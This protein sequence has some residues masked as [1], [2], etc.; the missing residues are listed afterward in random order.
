MAK[1]ITAKLVLAFLLVSITGLGLAAGIANWLTVREFKQL[2]LD[3]ARERFIAD[4][5]RYYEANGHWDGVLEGIRARGFPLPPPQANPQATPAPNSQPNLERR[6]R[7]PSFYFLLVDTRSQVLIPVDT[8]ETGDTITPDQYQAA[9]PIVVN[10]KQVGAMLVIGSA[11]PLDPL[12]ERFL[13]RFNQALLYAALGATVIALLLGVVLARNLTQPL[14]ALTAAIRKVT[15]GDLKQR[16]TVISTDELGDLSSAFN[17]MSEQL[18][19]L[20][21]SRRQM[22]ADVAHDLRTPLTVIGGYIESMRDGVLKPTTERL[23]LIQTEVQ[24]LHRLVEDLR[25]LSQADAGELSLNREPTAMPALLDQI[26]QSYRPIADK[27]GVA[28]KTDVRNPLAQVLADPDRLAQVLGNLITN[29]LRY[30][31]QGGEIV[32]RAWQNKAN[33]ALSVQDNGSGIAP[34]TLP[35]IFDRFYRADS[36]RSNGSESGLGLAIAKSIIEAH[37]GSI[38]AENQPEHGTAIHI[39]LPAI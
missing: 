31:A 16:V 21:Q 26:A 2:S 10:D 25:T 27:H 15:Q 3:Q 33:V 35:F 38:S 23:A 4:V 5:T 36:A 1:S 14:R 22:T 34:D 9:I 30:T 24:H 29:S 28:L 18:D 37:G 19:H 13:G 12:E 6:A 39:Q 11:P 32:L 20:I 8:Y 17:Q 7:P